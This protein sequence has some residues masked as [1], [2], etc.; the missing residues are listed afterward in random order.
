MPNMHEVI[1]MFVRGV[2]G[3]VIDC[4]VFVVLNLI[5]L[6]VIRVV[7]IQR[8]VVLYFS[9]AYYLRRADTTYYPICSWIQGSQL[10]SSGSESIAAKWRGLR[11]R[12]NCVHCNVPCTLVSYQQG[13]DGKRWIC[14]PCKTTKN[15]RE[16]SFFSKSHLQLK[17]IIRIVYCWAYD[18]T[19]AYTKHEA[20]VT[21]D[22]TIVDWF[23]FCREECETFLERN[24]REIGGFDE[25]GHQ[26]TVEIDESKY[27][28]GTSHSA[29]GAIESALE[30]VSPDAH[31]IVRRL[32]TAGGKRIK[33]RP[34]SAIDTD[35]SDQPSYSYQYRT[36]LDQ[37]S[38][39]T[40]TT[41]RQ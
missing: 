37:L 17:Q 40:T 4:A 26:I 34:L 25:N 18:M 29:T 30:Y 2:V 23:H 21:Q 41:A 22:H 28:V 12:N 36:S 9:V 32:A 27:F 33:M 6:Q 10:K 11:N 38:V 8:A 39:A 13:L 5:W 1:R 15:V 14:R 19:Q 24:P 35:H 3:M 7:C 31:C 16:G 20:E